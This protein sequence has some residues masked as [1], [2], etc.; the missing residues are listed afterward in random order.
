MEMTLDTLHCT[1]KPLTID[2]LNEYEGGA[3]WVAVGWVCNSV[4]LCC[5]IAASIMA[6]NNANPY[7]ALGVSITG[8][9]LGFAGQILTG[10]KVPK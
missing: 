7:V 10:I 9:V 2:E 5:G 4:A 1:F 3:W 6:A 8:S